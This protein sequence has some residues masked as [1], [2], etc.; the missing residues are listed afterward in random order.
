MFFIIEA[1]KEAILDFLQGSVRTFICIYRKKEHASTQVIQGT[2]K[3]LS[4]V[5]DDSNDDAN[6]LHKL[7]LTNTQVS[8]IR[9]VYNVINKYV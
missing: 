5:V 9:Q 2:L 6:F 4:N 7:L 8:I 1:A 3:L